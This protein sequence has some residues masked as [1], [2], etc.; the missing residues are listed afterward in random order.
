MSFP[1]FATPIAVRAISDIRVKSG[2]HYLSP[3]RKDAPDPA[4]RA[5]LDQFWQ[6]GENGVGLIQLDEKQM[7]LDYQAHIALNDTMANVNG[8]LI[9]SEDATAQAD[10]VANKHS[11]RTTVMHYILY[12]LSIKELT[13]G[14]YD[15]TVRVL[16]RWNCLAE[17]KRRAAIR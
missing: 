8:T 11:G 10:L 14:G 2:D 17:S 5:R 7:T 4:L 3:L 6:T 13:H 15:S 9:N 12:R 1:S 16:N